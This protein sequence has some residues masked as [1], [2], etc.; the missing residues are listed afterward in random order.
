M[1]NSNN[2]LN[3]DLYSELLAVLL[4]P[5]PLVAP[6]V[7]VLFKFFPFLG[8]REEALNFPGFDPE[9]RYSYKI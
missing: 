1:F 9:L 6:D 8:S 5:F 2:Y 3:V 4:R 7:A